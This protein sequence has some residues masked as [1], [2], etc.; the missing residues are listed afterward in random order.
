MLNAE[1][2]KNFRSHYFSKLRI[3]GIMKTT[4]KNL[5]K[6]VILTFVISA[7]VLSCAP[8][9]QDADRTQPEVPAIMSNDVNLLKLHKKP[10][11]DFQFTEKTLSKST[12]DSVF[13]VN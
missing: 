7:Y 11:A 5:I 9:A 10:F 1:L 12:S 3:E 4:K 8:N 13:S 2:A 6:F